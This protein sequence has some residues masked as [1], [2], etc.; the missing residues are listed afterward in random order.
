MCNTESTGAFCI[1]SNSDNQVQPSIGAVFKVMCP[2]TDL[3]VVFAVL[4][5]EADLGAVFAVLCPNR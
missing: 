4:R 1:R 5:P 3:G 2:W